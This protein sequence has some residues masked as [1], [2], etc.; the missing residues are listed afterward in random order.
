MSNIATT[1][2]FLRRLHNQQRQKFLPNNKLRIN[3][4]VQKVIFGSIMLLL[5][6]LYTIADSNVFLSHHAE[7][8]SLLAAPNTV[9][10]PRRLGILIGIFT[11][12]YKNDEE[13][14]SRHRKLFT[15]WNDPRVCS[16][17]DFEKWQKAAVPTSCEVMYTFV[18]GANPAAATEW[19]ELDEN[20]IGQRSDNPILVD[21]RVDS[22]FT[23]P[24][25]VKKGDVTRLNIRENMNQGK[26]PT[27]FKY[28]NQLMEMYSGDI[29]YAM[30]LDAD[31][32]LHLHEFFRFAYLHLPPPPYN[33]NMYVGSLRDKAYWPQKLNVTE[34]ALAN[35]EGYF[36]TEFE[37]VHLY[38]AGQCYIL[39][40]NLCKVVQQESRLL[41]QARNN[42]YKSNTTYMEG[43]EDHDIAAMVFHSPEP[44]HLT[45]IR[46]KQ[47]FWEHPVKGEPRWRRIW[48][49]EVARMEGRPFEGTFH[50]KDS[51]YET[52]MRKKR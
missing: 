37:G 44:V 24:D 26:S 1:R 9:Q 27:F 31:S 16:L 18:V 6:W 48:H 10:T 5:G 14:R 30:K 2:P 3:G 49:R 33:D 36:G 20:D 19:I 12:D 21:S 4:A 17:G 50:T 42:P 29:N 11:T 38:L 8:R 43:H 7:R 39:S 47:R 45:T 34:H 41:Q 51:S 40:Q 52:I 35:K 15:L 23:A 13:Y 32:I 28:A 22:N 25:L 46:R